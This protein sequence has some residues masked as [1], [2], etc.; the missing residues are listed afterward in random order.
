MK[1]PHRPG[2]RELSR[3][4][5]SR[6]LSPVEVVQQMLQRIDTL[7]KHL[8]S[9]ITITADHAM[10]QARVAEKQILSGNKHGPLLGIPYAAKDLLETKGILTTV[11]SKIMANNIPQSDAA[12]IQKLNDAGSILMGKTGLHEWAYGITS[13][14]PHFG[15]VTNPWDTTRIPGGSSGGS[16]AALAAGLCSFSLGSDTGGSIRIPAAF[17]G[18]TGLKPTFGRISRRGAFPLGHTL[19]TLGPFAVSVEDVALVYLA[20]AGHDPLDPSSSNKAVESFD[21]NPEP[22]LKGTRIG[23]PINFYFDN[24][25]PDVKTAT[26]AALQDLQDL[27]AELC[28]IE[29]PDI[30]AANSLHR[31]ILLAEA[32]SVHRK[33]IQAHREDF[34]MDVRALLEQG[35]FILATDYLNAQRARQEFCQDFNTLFANVDV[36]AAPAIPIPTAP[37]GKLEIEVDGRMENV[38]LATTRNIRALNLAGLPVLSVPCGF[39]KDNLPIGL[40]L[41][42]KNYC[43]T[44]VLKVGHAYQQTTD[45]HTRVAT[46]SK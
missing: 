13:T 9:F 22:S 4:Y 29:V 46:V 17:C 8:N 42:G 36:V 45:W 19:D 44:E 25:V 20:T 40:Q 41:I 23:V 16:T 30:E 18:V 6:A 32:S 21:F 37:I 24:L 38:R 28:E 3:L 27:G 14:N 2:I 34:G 1:I 33:R 15:P 5:E 10:A 35:Q 39:H 7:D 31:L 43:E 12:I 26:S 11:G